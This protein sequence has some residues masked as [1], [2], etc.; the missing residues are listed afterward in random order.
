VLT[1]K[2][3]KGTYIFGRNDA[4]QGVLIGLERQR[5]VG[6]WQC[7]QPCHLSH[8]FLLQKNNGYNIALWFTPFQSSLQT[9]MC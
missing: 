2:M 7:S 5:M 6:S 8:F 9:K 3:K 1:Y 4:C